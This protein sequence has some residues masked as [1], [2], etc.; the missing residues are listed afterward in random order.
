MV[1]YSMGRLA[2]GPGDVPFL[3]EL[4]RLNVALSRARLQAI[5]ISRRD[6]MFPPVSNPEQLMLA[7]R[8]IRA[9]SGST[10][11]EPDHLI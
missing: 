1:V 2:E 5:V 9:V 4:N 11:D 7:S 6:A 8:F 10:A 3:Y